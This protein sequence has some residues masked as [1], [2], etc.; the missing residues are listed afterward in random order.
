VLKDITSLPREQ[1]AAIKKLKDGKVDIVPHDK[2]GSLWAIEQRC[3]RALR[4]GELPAAAHGPALSDRGG[5][6]A[7]MNRFESLSREVRG[8]R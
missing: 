5:N 7:K 2:E 3:E 8:V 6:A 1:T 4:A